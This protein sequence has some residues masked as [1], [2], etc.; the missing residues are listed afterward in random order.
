MLGEEELECLKYAQRLRPYTNTSS[1][2]TLAGAIAPR[3]RC[4][5]ISLAGRPDGRRPGKAADEEA[6]NEEE[7]CQRRRYQ[8]RYDNVRLMLLAT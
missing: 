5:G 8:C 6:G 3:G 4:E 1:T 7:G 2:A